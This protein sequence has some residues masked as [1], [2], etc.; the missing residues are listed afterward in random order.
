MHTKLDV[1]YVLATLCSLHCICAPIAF[2]EEPIAEQAQRI[3]REAYVMDTHSDTTPKFE[4]EEWGFA[5]RHEDGH[6]DLPRLR[7]GGYDAVFWSIYM[8]KTEGDGA[9]LKKAIRR[10]DSVQELVRKYP[11]ELLLATTAADI[12]RA[13]SESKIACLMGVEGGHI[14]EGELAAL[15]A[16]FRLGA[17]YMTL[18]RSTRR[19]QILRARAVPSMLSTKASQVLAMK[20]CWR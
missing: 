18:I 14:I 20:S 9:A 8:G 2:S 12:R 19:G 15:R 11:D 13:S 3:H 17:R 10:M 6:M 4:Q 7:D 1:K 5:E 16:L